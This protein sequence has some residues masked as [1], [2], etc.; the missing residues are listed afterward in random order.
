MD[1]RISRSSK[2]QKS[3]KDYNKGF[4]WISIWYNNHGIV[5]LKKFTPVFLFLTIIISLNTFFYHRNP[6]EKSYI[7]NIKEKDI[8]YLLGITGISTAYWF[9]NVPVL[10]EWFRLCWRVAIILFS[11]F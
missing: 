7:N 6:K 2:P 9:F 5:I 3:F 10:K 1:K 8:F 4:Y 11:I